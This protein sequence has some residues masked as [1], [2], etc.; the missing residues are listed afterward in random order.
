MGR[1]EV[2][3]HLSAA[4]MIVNPNFAGAETEIVSPAEKR[5]RSWAE[6]DWGSKFKVDVPLNEADAAD[7]DALVLPGGD[8]KRRWNTSESGS[9]FGSR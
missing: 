9:A 3:P 2:L 7:Y 5:V 4:A 8:D 1:R 6:T